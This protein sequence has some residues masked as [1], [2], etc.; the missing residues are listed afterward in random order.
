MFPFFSQLDIKKKFIFL[1]LSSLVF[2]F[3]I[4]SIFKGLN[5]SCDILWQPTN[6]FWS[7]INHYEYQ[8]RTRDIFL[9]CQKGQY[10]HFM[11]I[12][13]YPLTF[14]EWEQVKIFW[15]IVNIIL[16]MSIPILICRSFNIPTIAS[17]LILGIFLTSHPTRMTF[18]LGQ[19]SLMIFF[20]LMLPFLTLKSINK[21]AILILSGISY[22][23]YSTGYILFLNLFIEKKYKNLFLTTIL[24]IFG[25][26]FY[27][28]YTET[29]LI[30]SFIDPLKFIIIDKMI[31]TGD[32]YS[33]LNIY[34][35]KDTNLLNKIIQLSVIIFFNVYFLYQIKDTRDN[36]AKLAVI[37]I[38]P[39]IFMPHGNY[40]YV[41]LLP[42][43]IYGIKNFELKISKYCVYL[44]L[45]YFYLHRIVKHK[46]DN[47]II[48]QNLMFIVFFIFIIFFCNHVKKLN[49]E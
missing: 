29:N 10:G 9:G 48:Y 34:L 17:F 44:A 45:Y 47:D 19:N 15:M 42:I 6:I 25:W 30:E 33:I 1:L 31:R 14:F 8:L 38:L 22:V 49:H 21:N 26:L 41:L 13:F 32:L 40:D 20:F 39:L 23:K 3:F 28:Y 7:G 24:T 18:N 12:L 5:N 16:A 36:L 37:C 46:I 35:L 4:Q 11:F 2:G 43:L 27:S